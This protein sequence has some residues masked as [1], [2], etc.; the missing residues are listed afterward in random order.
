MTNEPRIQVELSRR[1]RKDVKHLR[2]KYPHVRE[3]V[4]GFIDRLEAGETPGNQVQHIHYTVY[5]VR[6]INSDVQRGK[7]GGY[8]V[9]YYIK[10]AERILLITIYTKSEVSDISDEMIRSII[11]AHEN[12]EN[13]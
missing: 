5:K 8:R 2:K 13:T 7:S 11:E 3:D 4:Q 9:V 10:T 1:F 6:L 12:G